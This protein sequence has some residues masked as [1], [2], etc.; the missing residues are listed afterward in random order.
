MS[1][2]LRVMSDKERLKRLKETIADMQKA[3]I[4]SHQV[5]NFYK[6]QYADLKKITD[7]E[8]QRQIALKRSL[9]NYRQEVK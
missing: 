9:K 7:I 5:L 2:R 1:K 6:K 8:K 3:N 4:Y